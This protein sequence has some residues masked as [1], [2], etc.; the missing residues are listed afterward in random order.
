MN[1]RYMTLDDIDAIVS[2]EN[3]VWTAETT[4]APF[5]SLTPIK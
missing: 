5:P 2:L 1:I 3:K 4:P